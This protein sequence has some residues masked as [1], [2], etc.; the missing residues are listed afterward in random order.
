[1]HGI[2][3]MSCLGETRELSLGAVIEAPH[4]PSSK[5]KCNITRSPALP[6]AVPKSRRFNT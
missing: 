6:P 4:I 1:M 5:R 2:L 3:E